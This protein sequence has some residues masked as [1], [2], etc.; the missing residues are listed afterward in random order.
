[1][2][3]LGWQARDGGAPVFGFVAIERVIDEYGKNKTLSKQ[4]GDEYDRGIEAI[5]KEKERIKMAK[6]ELQLLA[7]DSE[8]YRTLRQQIQIDEFKVDLRQ[9]ELVRSLD[10]KK[11]EGWKE[12]YHDIREATAQVAAEK[13]LVAVF[14]MNSGPLPG[15]TDA[16]VMA[17]ISIRK[18]L[19]SDTKYDVTEDVL[20]IL[21]R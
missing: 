9:K 16:E 5:D 15:E 2:L 3:A 14:T 12:L 17:Q 18:V 13:G 19:Y 6:E 7:R 21:N 1:M 10:Q 4:L 11:V 8:K 20:G